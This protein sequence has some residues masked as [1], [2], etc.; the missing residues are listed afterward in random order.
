MPISSSSRK[1]IDRVAVNF[2]R[3]ANYHAFYRW[4]GT[5]KKA[6]EF[7]CTVTHKQAYESLSKV[8]AFR[9]RIDPHK[10]SSA[11]T[12][13]LRQLSKMGFTVEFSAQSTHYQ[14]YAFR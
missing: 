5:D 3:A 6:G 1:V 8:E 11:R 13:I 2:A 9:F 12:K 7:H 14:Y 10:S 4:A